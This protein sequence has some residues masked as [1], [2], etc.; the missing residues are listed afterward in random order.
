MDYVGLFSRLSR[1]LFKIED[2]KPSMAFKEHYAC[3]RLCAVDVAAI[4]SSL[5][6]EYDKIREN[7]PLFVSLNELEASLNGIL[8][9]LRWCNA[10][11]SVTF[12]VSDKELRSV[13]PLGRDSHRHWT[14]N[15]VGPLP[16]CVHE[17]YGR[18]RR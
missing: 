6:S 15:A 9:L 11:R 14:G 1:L 13:R 10:T 8:A 7:R 5:E 18:K 2:E 17:E 16:H 3:L 12:A 4:V